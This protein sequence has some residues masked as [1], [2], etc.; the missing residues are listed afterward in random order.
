MEIY[1]FIV[2]P[3]KRKT[4]R[5]HYIRISV[6]F[7]VINQNMFNATSHKIQEFGCLTITEEQKDLISIKRTKPRRG[8]TLR[9]GLTMYRNGRK[10]LFQA[11]FGHKKTT[12]I[13]SKLRWIFGA[14]GGGRTRT[15]LP[16]R[17][18][19]SRTSAN[20]ITPASNGIIHHFKIFVN[21]PIEKIYY[22]NKKNTAR[23]I[24]V[25]YRCYSVKMTMSLSSLL[26]NRKVLLRHLCLP[27]CRS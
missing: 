16:P 9:R 23:T 18:F 8:I 26:S 17:D 1:P 25:R 22:I 6:V 3:R 14:G 12:V 7:Q 27:N 10:A 5:I 24:S 19:E 20:S 11:I 21:T 2:I 15:V 4:I 13:L